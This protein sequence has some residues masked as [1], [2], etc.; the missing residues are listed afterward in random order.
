MDLVVLEAD[1]CSLLYEC[2]QLRKERDELAEKN[3]KVRINSS[4]LFLDNMFY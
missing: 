3:E 2:I 1:R 4:W